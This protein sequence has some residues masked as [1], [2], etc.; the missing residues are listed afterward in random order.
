MANGFFWLDR[1]RYGHGFSIWHGSWR[2]KPLSP[3]IETIDHSHRR[4]L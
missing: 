3:F 2:S 1:G 4:L